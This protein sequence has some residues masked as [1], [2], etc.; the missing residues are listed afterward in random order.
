MKKLVAACV[1]LGL[2]GCAAVW[3]KGSH[4]EFSNSRLITLKYDP[5]FASMGDLQKEA[6]NYCDKYGKDVGSG[7]GDRNASW[8]LRTMT[9]YCIPREKAS[10][11]K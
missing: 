1:L 11:Q 10:P 8:G 5:D 4:V 2:T 3:G 7:E 6:Q 9:F